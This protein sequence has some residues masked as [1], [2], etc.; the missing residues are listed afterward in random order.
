ME[1]KAQNPYIIPFSI[2]ISGALIGAGIYLSSREPQRLAD[3]R[4]GGGVIEE[5]TMR[6]VAESD[7]ILGSPNA[8]V[9]I[10]EYSDTECPYCKM[11]HQTMHRIIDEYG[12][13]GQVAWVYRHFPIDGLH[14]LARAEAHATECAAELGG[15][16]KFWEYA[17]QIYERTNSNDSLP[18][19]ELPKIASDIGLNLN[20]FNTCQASNRH[21]NK[22]IEDEQDARRSG[23]AGTPHSILITKSGEKIA[24]KGAQPYDVVKA[25]ID[26]ALTQ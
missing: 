4:T 5:I 23:G 16:A 6:P 10:V 18:V 2:V 17:D 26:A 12:K 7:H 11:F 14:K 24:I 22:I 15:N 20:D 21:A 13:N 9:V 1:P 8:E 3:N 25:V 19:T